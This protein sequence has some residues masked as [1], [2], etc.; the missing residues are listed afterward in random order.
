M[1][2]ISR[3]SGDR[4]SSTRW[5][6]DS[7]ADS[8]AYAPD[9]HCWNCGE[10]GHVQK[11]CS[12]GKPIQ[13]HRCGQTGHKEK[14]CDFYPISTY[15]SNQ[16]Y[17]YFNHYDGSDQEYDYYNYYGHTNNYNNFKY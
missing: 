12:H 5:K 10:S 7:T 13:C 6:R 14:N 4:N 11:V 17:N 1:I 16:D 15:E 3:E 2:D 8:K 9:A